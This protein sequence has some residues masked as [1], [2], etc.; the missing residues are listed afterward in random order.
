MPSCAWVS[1]AL[2]LSACVSTVR[3]SSSDGNAPLGAASAGLP[4]TTVRSS[5]G[6]SPPAVN[7]TTPHNSPPLTRAC[8]SAH[9][10]ACATCPTG[11]RWSCASTTEVHACR[12]A[13]WISPWLLP[14]PWRCSPRA[15]PRWSAKSC[16]DRAEGE[17]LEPS[18]AHRPAVF[19]TAALPV[20]RTLRKHTGAWY[21]VSRRAVLPTTTHRTW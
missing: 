4:P 17:G 14:V 3:F 1:L 7:P 2:L 5:A 10:C 11:A 13:S 21:D 12:G 6:A 20:R 18:W 8:P 9:G 16:L 19:K 15:S